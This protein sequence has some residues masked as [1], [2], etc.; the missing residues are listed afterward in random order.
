MKTL[1]KEPTA[2][3]LSPSEIS[4]RV[5]KARAAQRIW[6]QVPLL[7]RIRT[8]RRFWSFMQTRRD[9]VVRVMHEETG[10]PLAEIESMEL[11][12]V[13]LIINYFTRN[14]YRLL[15]DQPAPHPWVMFNKRTY[16]R[17][18]P[19][20]LV[21]LITPW[22]YPL[23]IPLGDSIPALIAGNAVVVKPS[24]W[25]P[26]TALHIERIVEESGLFPD[27][28]FQVWSG[29]GSVG[30]AVIERADMILFT[31]STRTGRAVA[32]AA[33]ERLIPCVLELGG[34]H[35]MIVAADAALN[36]AAK[37]AAWGR[38]ANCGQT[39]VGVERIYVAREAYKEFVE[40]LTKEAAALRQGV[41]NSY[42]VDM[43]RM[44]F[45]K[46][47]ETVARHL[48]DARAKGARIVGEGIVD[49]ERLL[50]AP[51]LILDATP[52]MLCMQEEIFGPVLPVCPV[53]S[54]EE[55]VEKSNVGPFGLA[56][57]MWTKDLRRG[58]WLSR[59]MQCG[60]IGVNDLMSHYVVASLP[61][62][63][64]K[65]SGLGRR[66]GEEGLRMFC[67][68]QSV[69]VHEWPANQP[70]VWWFPYSRMKTKLVN[71]IGKLS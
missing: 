70:E 32:K 47:V 20:G 41:E 4:A 15:K 34:K 53:A 6:A 51:T 52:D 9:S 60:M 38:F 1:I 42:D 64:V 25:T 7:E 48:E 69:I 3:N 21:G 10:K 11:D 56:G 29:D 12:A 46:Q 8:I 61:F 66:H 28:L 62:G 50:I 43:G 40:L 2:P 33:A 16:I 65:Q 45:P 31:G 39:C 71:W 14:G 26:K 58:E 44:I 68:T 63:G 54:A 36:R 27:G 67:Q 24:E 22:N 23:M 55:A 19:R 30:Q 5:E 57:S 18:M 35:A 37:A 17:F 59:E 49:A 13:G